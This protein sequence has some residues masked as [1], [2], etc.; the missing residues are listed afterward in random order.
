MGFPESFLFS[1]V[2]ERSLSETVD[3]QVSRNGT[4]EEDI[5][6]SERK[7]IDRGAEEPACP[8]NLPKKEQRYASRRYG[9]V[10]TPRNRLFQGDFVLVE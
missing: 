5:A 9:S 8:C 10:W 3:I 7:F 4:A 6:S 2:D 1:A